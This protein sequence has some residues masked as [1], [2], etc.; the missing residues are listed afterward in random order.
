MTIRIDI[1]RIVLDGFD[2]DRHGADA[3]RAAIGAELTRLLEERPPA[4]GLPGGA[5]PAL[6]APSVQLE[7][8][9]SPAQL[10]TQ[11]AGAVHRSL[12]R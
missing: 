3:V 11:V 10:G 8:G 4:G 7:A 5:V 2:F 12:G 1:E 9:T 6:R